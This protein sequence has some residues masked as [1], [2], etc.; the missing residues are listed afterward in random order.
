MA[1]KLEGT[2]IVG[3]GFFFLVVVGLGCLHRTPFFYIIT[4]VSLVQ[5]NEGLGINLNGKGRGF[6]LVGKF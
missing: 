2:R 3:L 6:F 1:S 4:R 5:R